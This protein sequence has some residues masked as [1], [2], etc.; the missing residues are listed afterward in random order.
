[1]CPCSEVPEG[2]GMAGGRNGLG[3][4]GMRCGQ[5]HIQEAG[6]GIPQPPAQDSSAV[7]ARTVPAAVISHIDRA[8]SGLHL[9]S[10]GR[11]Y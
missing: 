4:S 11:R 2:A 1:M 5:P 7:K 9:I 8:L 3:W 6:E 10:G